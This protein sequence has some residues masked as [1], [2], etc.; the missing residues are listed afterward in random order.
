MAIATLTLCFRNQQ[1]FDRKLKITKGEACRL[2]TESTR[3]LRAV[4]DAFRR[5]VKVIR[6]K[7]VPRDPS[8]LRI[9]AACMRI[10]R[11]IESNFPTA[12][13]VTTPA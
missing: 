13:N 3:N 9:N 7:N 11:F 4:C 1:L 8:F 6:R 2:M 12:G 5:Y 10:D